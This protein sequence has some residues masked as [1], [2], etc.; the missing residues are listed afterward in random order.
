MANDKPNPEPSTPNPN[1]RDKP[2]NIRT[3]TYFTLNKYL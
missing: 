3:I 1:L 2:N